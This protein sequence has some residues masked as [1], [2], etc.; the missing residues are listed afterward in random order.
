MGAL[1]R[2]YPFAPTMLRNYLPVLLLLGCVIL[3]AV[4][5]LGVAHLTVRAQPTAVKSQPYESGMSPLGDARERFSVKFYLVAMLFI[6]FDIETVFMIPWGV[7]YR[8]LSCAVPLV[9]GACPAGSLS[10]FGLG[11]MLVF[12]AILV[13]GFVYVWKKGALTWD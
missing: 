12:A 9:A 13:V 11:E 7:Y 6:V 1:R 2:D 10:F 4:L 8:Q 5:I 3:N